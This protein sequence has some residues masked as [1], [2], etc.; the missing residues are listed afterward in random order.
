MCLLVTPIETPLSAEELAAYAAIH[1]NKPNTT[2]Y[3][4]AGAQMEVSYQADT[5]MYIDKKI[6]ALAAA[7]VNNT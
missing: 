3:N 1:T 2:I 5:K 6:N 7:I 4:D